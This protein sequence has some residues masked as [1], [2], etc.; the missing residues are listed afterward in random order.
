MIRELSACVV[1]GCHK[2]RFWMKIIIPTSADVVRTS[3]RVRVYPADAVLS[4]DGFLPSADAL[5]C[6]RV[7]A[8]FARTRVRV[9]VAAQ[10]WRGRVRV[11]VGRPRGRG[12]THPWLRGCGAD[13]RTHP[14]GRPTSVRTRVDTR[15]A[16]TGPCGCGAM[17]ARTPDHGGQNF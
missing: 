7:H 9:L 2:R 3:A 16:A 4:A 8:T 14:R 15:R 1:Q 12:S 10:T 11:D 17:S 5:M 13:D 6:P